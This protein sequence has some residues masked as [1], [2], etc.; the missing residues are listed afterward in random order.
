MKRVLHSIIFLLFVPLCSTAQEFQATA[1][2]TTVGVGER[3]RVEFTINASGDA[4]T[5]PTF[6]GFR[7]LSGPNQSTSMQFVNGRSSYSISYNYILTALSEGEFNI[8]PASIKVGSKVVESNELKIKVVGGGSASVPAEEKHSDENRRKTGNEVDD[9][10][11]IRSHVSKANPYQGEQMVVTY[12]L[13]FNYNIVDNRFNTMPSLTGFYSEDLDVQN[14]KPTTEVL[15]G[16]RFNVVTL[17]KTILIPQRS[18]MLEIDPLEMDLTIQ[19]QVQGRGR[20][21]FDQ[22]FGS[23]KNIPV[24]VRSNPIKVD[25]KPLPSGKPADFSGAVGKFDVSLSSDRTEVKSNES[26]NVSFKI[27]GTGNLKLLEKPDI[28]FPTDFEVYDPKVNDNIAV[29]SGGISGSRTYQYL[30]IPRYK[31]EFSIDPVTFSYF[32]PSRE[33]Y[34]TLTTDG[35][36]FK[37]EKGSEEAS[38]AVSFRGANKEDIKLLGSDIRYIKTQTKLLQIGYDFFGSALFYIL[39]LLPVPLFFAMVYGKK[40]Y[41]AIRGDAV[42][43]KKTRANR[44]AIKRLSAAKKFMHQ[45]NQKEFYEEVFKALY[46]FFGDKFNIPTSGLNK[47]TIE[48]SLKSRSIDSSLIEKTIKSLDQCEM[49]RFAPMSDIS[50]EDFYERAVDLLSNLQKALK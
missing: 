27:N 49:A 12:K 46:G 1:S 39:W 5:P 33:R 43:M 20:S 7:I 21:L 13:F 25:V 29:N 35:L 8:P 9:N 22:F 4:F 40:K 41:D 34:V 32:D 24:T 16:R 6:N 48:S 45:N 15:N 31:G 3:F 19:Q 14:T 23:Y 2:K 10:L 26:I 18:G 42:Y 38:G 17:K 47:E 37:I 11:F 36:N 44:M 28:D 30:T 50:M